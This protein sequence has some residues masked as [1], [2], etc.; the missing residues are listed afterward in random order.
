MIGATRIRDQ[1]NFG[2]ALY[3]FCRGGRQDNIAAKYNIGAGPG[4]DAIDSADDRFCQ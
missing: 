4:R 3:K 1:P 2:K